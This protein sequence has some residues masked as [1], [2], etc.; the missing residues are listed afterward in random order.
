MD[1]YIPEE[2]L[3]IQVSHTPHKTDDTWQRESSALVK[4]SNQLD[5]R[6]L[7]ILSYEEE[8]SFQVEGK[9]IRVL[10]VWKWL[11]EQI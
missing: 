7:L 4:L 9:E 11:L 3:A 1:F 8:G 10:P 2:A 5:C 6:Q